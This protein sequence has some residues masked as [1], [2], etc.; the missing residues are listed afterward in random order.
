[1]PRC[2]NGTRKNKKT[3]NCEPILKTTRVLERSVEKSTENKIVVIPKE[4]IYHIDDREVFKFYNEN[5]ILKK[6]Q[7]HKMSFRD[8]NTDLKKNLRYML[9]DL[10]DMC[11]IKDYKKLKKPE[12]VNQ[13]NQCVK[14]ER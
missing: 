5:Q 7:H 10:A 14:F 9:E 8:V 11:D 2:K 6:G 1:M 3:G 12:L 13:L 4:D